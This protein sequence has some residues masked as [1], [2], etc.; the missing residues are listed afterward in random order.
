MKHSIVLFFTAIFAYTIPTLK[1]QN[2][3]LA[4]SLASKSFQE[5]E[6]LFYESKPDTLKA[7]LYA[8]AKYLKALKEKDTM[9]I[10]W[11][12]YYLADIKNN[13]AI[14][15]NFCD[16]LIKVYSVKPNKN[17]PVAI[18]LNKLRF[19]YQKNK[20][21][22]MTQELVK[23]D[24]VLRSFKNDSLNILKTMYHGLAKSKVG[25]YKSSISSFLRVE[26]YLDK[27]YQ[28]PNVNNELKYVALNISLTYKK[29][30]KFDSALFYNKKA[31]K[32][33]QSLND[34]IAY[35]YTF[36]TEGEI[37]FETKK[38][39]SSIDSYIQSIPYISS[40][41]NYP[42]L[43]LLFTKLGRSFKQTNTLNKALEFHLKADSI[44]N[45]RKIKSS[46][47]KYSFS[48]LSNHYKNQGNL[49]KQLHYVNKL[50]DL[51]EF[52]LTEKNKIQETFTNE[53]D[54]P[55]L[56]AER[57]RIVEELESKSKRNKIIFTSLLAL[58]LAL[59]SYQI[60]KNSIY[61]KRF[62][63][64]I[65]K[66][67][68]DLKTIH[69]STKEESKPKLELSESIVAS[70]LEQLKKFEESNEFINIDLNLQ[71]LASKFD[72]N[73]SYLSKV[74]NYHKHTSFSNYINKLRIEYCV[75]QLKSN[76]LWKKYTIKAIANEVG[77]N[78]AES[79]SKAFYKYTEL[80]PSY[81]IKELKK[82]APSS[83]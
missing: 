52:E 57:K 63:T 1:G 79:F 71:Y 38:Y 41:E 46:S 76:E 55:N 77:F 28:G 81:F 16:S 21:N 8:N 67:K 22:L 56:L 25:D 73:A 42:I 15:L 33:F 48:F 51:K 34:T 65:S 40:D 60:R 78:K 12:K 62:Q 61:K 49:E 4:D 26:K 2:S 7:I 31:S 37:L 18:H 58:L 54:I 82:K 45:Q 5:L 17:F 11:S 50:L 36:F 6:D 69:P 20:V 44:Y 14:Y 70:I 72:T 39:L 35:G 10:I 9:E 80:R 29:I 47:L 27:A 68:D 53:F 19:F 59:I 30:S 43:I 3:V 66:Q 83:F 23:I 24:K 64:L 32:L 75:E 74:I 13:D